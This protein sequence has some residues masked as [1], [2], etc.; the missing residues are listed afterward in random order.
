MI[1]K[2]LFIISCGLF[3]MSCSSNKDVTTPSSQKTEDEMVICTTLFKSIGVEITDSDHLFDEF[4][5]LNNQT[6][7]KKRI[8][9]APNNSQ[10]N[11]AYYTLID[12]SLQKDLQ[13]KKV[14]YTLIAV[15][16][17]IQIIEEPY[18]FSADACHIFKVSGKETITT[19]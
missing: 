19:M 17:G 18:V 11:T 7:E 13:D 16:S 8:I 6:K 15:K 12:D 5:L 4:Y 3:I 9:A 10:N 1:L 14:P 2:K